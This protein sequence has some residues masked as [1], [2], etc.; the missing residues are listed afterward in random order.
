MVRRRGVAAVAAAALAVTAAGCEWAQP[1]FGPERT[2]YNPFENALG[3]EDADDLGVLWS[4]PLPHP[5]SDVVVIDGMVVTAVNGQGGG[6]AY[7]VAVDA[8]T[9]ESRWGFSA[10]GAGCSSAGCFPAAASVS[11]ADGLVFVGVAVT[12]QGGLGALDAETGATVHVYTGDTAYAPVVAGGRVYASRYGSKTG[13]S[14]WD[15]DTGQELFHAPGNTA[16]TRPTVAAG[17]VYDVRDGTMRAYDA[18]GQAGCSGDPVVCAPLWSAA[19]A[20]TPAVAGGLAAWGA[21]VWNAAGCGTEVCA[22]IWTDGVATFTSGAALAAGTLYVTNGLGELEAYAAAGCGAPTCAPRWRAPGPSFAAP[23]VANGVV[24]VTGGDRL[25]AYDAGGCGAPV[26]APLA[27]TTLPAA[28]RSEVVV[29]G[30]R[31]YLALTDSTVVALGA[32]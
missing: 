27:T 24:Y 22:P 28:V 10:P 11:A 26:C 9:G 29:S 2:G 19:D 4:A 18:A 6:A 16:F 17:H 31:I 1:R 32:T 20:G 23:S 30:G 8:D 13:L 7:V 12:Q 15:V 5:G 21:A 25:I 3:V 14:A